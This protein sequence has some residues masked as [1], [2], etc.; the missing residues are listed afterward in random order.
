[1]PYLPNESVDEDLQSDME[2]L[3]H[4]LVKNLP[5]GAACELQMEIAIAEQSEAGHQTEEEFL[6]EFATTGKSK[7]KFLVFFKRDIDSPSKFG[8]GNSE[9]GNE[10][11]QGIEKTIARAR[12]K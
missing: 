1:M 9:S 4:N 3:V 10:S 7:I 11:H 6:R 8:E 5:M 2:V 12:V